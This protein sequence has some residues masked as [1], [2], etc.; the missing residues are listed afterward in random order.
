[1]DELNPKKCQV[2]DCKARRQYR[3]TYRPAEPWNVTEPLP[4]GWGYVMCVCGTHRREF[5]FV[6]AKILRLERI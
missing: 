3:V 4:D 6:G 1:M 5:P 2:E